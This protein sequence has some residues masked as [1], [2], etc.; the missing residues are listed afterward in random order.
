MPTYESAVKEDIET[1]V[2]WR[3]ILSIAG[4]IKP[5]VEIVYLLPSL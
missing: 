3:V 2:P 4:E 1:P 5:E